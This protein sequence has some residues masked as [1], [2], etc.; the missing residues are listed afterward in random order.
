MAK[1]LSVDASHRSKGDFH[2]GPNTLIT[3]LPVASA[4]DEKNIIYIWWRRDCHDWP[5][6]QC[7]HCSTRRRQR[8][9]LLS[10]HCRPKTSSRS[11]DFLRR[12]AFTTERRYLLS[13]TYPGVQCHHHHDQATTDWHQ[14]GDSLGVSSAKI[15]ITVTM[16]LVSTVHR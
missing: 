1:G 2:H 7:C 6:G 3:T 8:R 13:S 14:V 10:F 5:L 15:N 9:S 16:Y 4:N 11:R 12:L